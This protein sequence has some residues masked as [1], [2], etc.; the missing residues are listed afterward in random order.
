LI[1]STAAESTEEKSREELLPRV[2]LNL[3]LAAP[4]ESTEEKQS[5]EELLLSLRLNLSLVALK[6]NEMKTAV[7]QCTMAL[8]LDVNNE[9]ALFRRGQALLAMH[10]PEKAAEDF[11]KVIDLNS[12]NK[13]ALRQIALC[14]KKIA[15]FKQ[16]DKMMFKKMFGL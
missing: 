1:L 10:E 2:R 9:K 16:K 5:R 11:S 15:E 12:E 13:A 4:A 6:T 8:E 7:E 3:S 14:R